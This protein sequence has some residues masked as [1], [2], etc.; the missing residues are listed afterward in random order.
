MS[1]W[2]RLFSKQELIEEQEIEEVELSIDELSSQVNN[3]LKK[4]NNLEST[5]FI[6]PIMDSLKKIK[7]IIN[8]LM[9]HELDSSYNK[10]LIIGANNARKRINDQLMPL[11]NLKT[12]TDLLSVNKLIKQVELLLARAAKVSKQSMHAQVIFRNEMNLL[13]N[14]FDKLSELLNELK[15]AVSDRNE[16]LESFSNL[17]N[18]VKSLKSAINKVNDIKKEELN[19][20]KRISS[21][22]R[23]K[24]FLSSEISR[25]KSIE[26]FNELFN[27][28]NSLKSINSKKSELEGSIM[29]IVSKFSRA[30]KKVFRDESF[31]NEFLTNPLA[32]INSNEGLFNKKMNQL[33]NEV[34]SG[35]VELSDREKKRTL[36]A[37]SDDSIN[38]LINDYKKLINKERSLKNLDFSLLNKASV[39]ERRL[40]DLNQKVN[41]SIKSLDSFK[42]RISSQLIEVD[43]I[44]AKV[45]SLASDCYPEN[46]KLV[47]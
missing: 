32:F 16:Q 39:F 41:A 35:K 38:D 45:E 9:I 15:E 29:N 36:K 31:V 42:D 37:L 3:S 24:S 26:S 14:S 10:A 25:I 21:Y 11:L 17:V 20:R 43:A 28:Q 2:K 6:E 27:A 46:V 5:D 23:D 44:K 4:I 34:N 30:L 40:M 33:I 13:S 22:E 47:L 18:E 1:F 19:V 7:S 12:P 8:D